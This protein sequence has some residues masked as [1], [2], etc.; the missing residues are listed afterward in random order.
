MVTN[1]TLLSNRTTFI[2]RF[3]FRV[4][5]LIIQKRIDRKLQPLDRLNKWRPEFA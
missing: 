4:F 3:S 2:E 5:H 1:T